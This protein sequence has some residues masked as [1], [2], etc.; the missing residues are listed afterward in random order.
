[1]PSALASTRNG[2]SRAAAPVVAG[3]TRADRIAAGKALRE[4]VPRTSHAA[5]RAPRLRTNPLTLIAESNRGRLAALLPIRYGRMLPSPFTFYRGTA[6]I[7]AADLASTP[8]SGLRVQAC[9]DAH[10]ANFG[11]FLTPERRLV[12]DIN[13]FDETLPAPWE[14]DVK[15]LAASLVLAARDRRFDRTAAREAAAAATRSYRDHMWALAEKP[16]LEV[17]Y[18]S[19]DATRAVDALARA[20]TR[21][22]FERRAAKATAP[23]VMSLPVATEIAADRIEIRDEPP[24]IFHP[25]GALARGLLQD[26]RAALGRYRARLRPDIAAL[27]SRY[28]LVDIAAKV[29]G[30]GSVGTRCAVLLLRGGADEYLVLQAKEARRSVLETYAGRSEYSNQ[31]ERVVVGQRLMQAASDM[32]LG[33]TVARGRDYYVRQLRDGKIKPLI[34]RFDAETLAQYGA[35]CGWALAAAHARSGDPAQI[36]GYIGKSD[37]F[38]DSITAFGEVYAAQCE[39]DHAA[40]ATAVRRGKIAV[41]EEETAS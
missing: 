3:L 25:H 22:R 16:M 15:R 41:A 6:A 37:R 10:L 39:R 17:W 33:W 30:V 35:A 40:F 12:F 20:D 8:T 26:V 29:V 32:L 5:W 36:A 24:L 38:V 27:V 4:T 28:E 19:I 11:G 1:M 14:W 9:G 23:D 18:Y 34:E 13:D 21:R 31:G 7:M 2:R